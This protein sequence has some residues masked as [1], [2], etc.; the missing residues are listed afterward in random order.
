M[1]K[2]TVNTFI[3]M[4]QKGEKISALTAYDYTMASLMDQAG[5][6]LILIGD[7]CG[8]VIAGHDTTIPVTMEEIIYHTRSV[9]RGV[10]RAFVVADMPYMSF[11]ESSEKAI[12]NA[13]ELMQKGRA[14]AVK[15]EGGQHITRTVEKITQIGIPVLGHLGLTPQS[16]YAFGGFKVQ[17]RETKQAEKLKEDALALQEAGAFAIVLEKI[18]AELAGEITQSLEIPTIG[19]G[20]GPQCDGQILVSYDML[21][22]N[23][24]FNPKFLRKYANLNEV[25]KTAVDKYSDDVKSGQYPSDEESY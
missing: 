9:R 23:E 5:L 25:I 13:G 12:H 4:K 19:I 15:L 11:Q 8:N 20:A 14:E 24:K 7:S 17:G 1:D 2:V 6:D 21:G 16:V 10:D 18:P 22:L 3:K